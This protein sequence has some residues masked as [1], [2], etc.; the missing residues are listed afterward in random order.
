MAAPG[1]RLWVARYNG[2]GDGRDVAS[3]VALS[4]DGK[5]VFVTGGSA[6]TASGSDYLTVAYNATTGARLWAARYNG[7]AN[8]DDSARAMAVSPGGG[9]V[10]VTGE[11]LGPSSTGFAGDYVTVAYRSS[12]GKQLW[13]ARYD[14]PAN[15]SDAANAISVARDGGAVFVTGA[16]TGKGDGSFP[17]G[18]ATVA[19]KAA[20]GAQLWVSRYVGQEDENSANAVASP[21]GNRV[22]VTGFSRGVGGEA[23]YATVA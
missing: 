22:F 19:Y 9:T 21:G 6:G 5:R 16:S 20:T 2:P 18:Y 4:P 15:E 13:V 3:S 8:K 7:P 1:A 17:V 12:D 11:S 10:F 23:G 14:G